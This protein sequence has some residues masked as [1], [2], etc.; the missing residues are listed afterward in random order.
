MTPIYAYDIAPDA[1]ARAL[2]D[3][4]WDSPPPDDGYRWLHLDLTRPD[5]EHWLARNLPDIP[6]RAMA[7]TET[8][9]RCDAL[10]GGL[11]LNLRAINLNAGADQVDMVSLRI[12]VDA[13]QVITVR[14]RKV[15]AAETLR[16]R[17]EQGGAPVDLVAFV[18][19]LA[20]L[21]VDRIE[22]VALDYEDRIDALEEDVHEQEVL[23]HDALGP[24]RRRVIKLRRYCGPQREALLR[25]ARLEQP[26]AAVAHPQL[27]E[28]ANR[29]VR[30]VEE[31]DSLRD[32]IAALHDHMA[33]VLSA[34][35]SRNSYALSVVAAV[36]LPL[37]FLT[38]LFGVNIAG[39]PGT[40]WAWAFPVFAAI[41]VAV[42]VGLFFL[43][44]AI[45]WI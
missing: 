7:A 2:V 21:I 16:D 43:F 13:R 34:Q 42:A 39:M 36:F 14:R 1:T 23:S 10:P 17:I 45:R 27:A 15:F 29:M 41:N 11:M 20:D 28:I 22:D 26:I 9:P 4:A 40:G 12:W 5:T 33:G 8:R 37:G 35:H 30:V 6:G 38:G 44:R 19:V 31:L 3:G 18:D 24:L 25:L 32:R